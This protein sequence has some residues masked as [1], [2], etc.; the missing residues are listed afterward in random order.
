MFAYVGSI[1]NLKDLKDLKDQFLRILST[2]GRGVRLCYEY[3]NPK[4]P[5]GQTPA[6]AANSGPWCACEREASLV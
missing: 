1:Q 4:G 2:Q 3:S 5:K 6:K